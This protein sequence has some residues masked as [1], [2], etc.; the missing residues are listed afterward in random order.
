MK[1]ISKL[2]FEFINQNEMSR[3]IGG[4]DDRPYGRPDYTSAKP[5]G[6][7][8]NSSNYYESI[9]GWLWEVASTRL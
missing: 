2:S 3:I 6:G 9:L 1:E 8:D 5:T 4:M 7:G